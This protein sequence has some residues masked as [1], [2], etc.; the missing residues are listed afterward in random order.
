MDTLQSRTQQDI[1]LSL[2]I[3][4]LIGNELINDLEE[5]KKISEDEKQDLL[6]ML[7]E[8]NELIRQTAQLETDFFDLIDSYVKRETE[9]ENVGT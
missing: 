3:K 1:E 6:K 7:N 2:K 9:E 5:K 4:E 8:S